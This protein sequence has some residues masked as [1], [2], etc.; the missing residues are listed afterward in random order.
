MVG[1]ADQDRSE[2]V[3]FLLSHG[4]DVNAKDKEGW[5]GLLLAV[6]QGRTSV[7]PKHCWTKAPTSMPN[8][9][10]AVTYSEAGQH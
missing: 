1:V 8:A 10:A 3:K 7:V 5:T 9:S 6:D 2:A 4:A